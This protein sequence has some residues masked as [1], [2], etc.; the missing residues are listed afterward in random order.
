MRFD[1]VKTDRNRKR[2]S[3]DL[4]DED[5]CVLGRA[6][7]IS[8]KENERFMEYA[9]NTNVSAKFDE[10]TIYFDTRDFD[11]FVG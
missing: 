5:G 6:Y 3:C 1:S 2:V 4:L 7:A 9:E 10:R 8:Y 11:D